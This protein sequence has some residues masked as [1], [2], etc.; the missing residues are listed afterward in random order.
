MVT[1]ATMGIG[2]VLETSRLGIRRVDPVDLRRLQAQGAFVVDIRPERVRRRE[3]HIPGAAVMER[4]ILEWRLDQSSGVAMAHGPERD[5]LVVIV[6]N[7]G[8][9][10]SL[11]A[12]DLRQIGFLRAAD[13]VGGF[14][15]YAAAGLP[16]ERH[17]SRIV[18]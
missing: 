7:E 11:A 14:R 17:P 6:C 15:A 9:A 3:G 2:D 13:L 18:D 10:S 8:F 12:R 16:V 1:A 5:Q 4:N